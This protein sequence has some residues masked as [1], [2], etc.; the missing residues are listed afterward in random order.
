MVVS[1]DLKIVHLGQDITQ[2]GSRNLFNAVCG[3]LTFLEILPRSREAEMR[4]QMTLTSS[5]HPST[6]RMILL[7]YT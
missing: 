2:L 7:F 4:N 3:D 1:I 6:E 5:T